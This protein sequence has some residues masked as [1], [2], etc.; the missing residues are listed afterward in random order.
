LI[1][2][3]VTEE[4]KQKA[5]ERSLKYYYAHNRRGRIMA[6]PIEATPILKNKDA[7]AFLNEMRCDEPVSS[8]RVQWLETL[9]EAS[10]SAEGKKK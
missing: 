9:A 10:K 1:G 5:R 8:D 2:D 4:Q 6:R 7:D 3:Y